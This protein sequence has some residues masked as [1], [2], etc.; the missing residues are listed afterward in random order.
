MKGIEYQIGL[1]YTRGP[2]RNR[3][4]SFVSLFSILGI[5]IGIATILTVLSVM[6]GFREEIREKVLNFTAHGLVSQF[7]GNIQDWRSIEEKLKQ[8]KQ[9][10]AY[11]PYLEFQ[12]ILKT[13]SNVRGT[14][15]RG[16]DP[17]TEQNVSDLEASLSEGAISDLTPK[18]WNVLLGQSLARN[19]G[20]KQGDRLVL[21]SSNVSHTPVGT[22]P[23]LRRLTVSGIFNTGMS[24][25]DNH[26]ALMNIKDAQLIMQAGKEVTGVQL[27]YDDLFQAPAISKKLRADLGLDYWV[28]SW[29]DRNRNFFKALEMEK[30]LLM[31]IMTLIIAVATFNI[32]SSLIMLVIEKKGDIAILKTMGMQTSSI[33]K[34]F[35]TQ[36]C[37]IGLSG[38]VLGTASGI[39]LAL[40]VER[41]VAGIENLT[42]SKFLS[43]DVYP[44]TEVPSQL[45]MADIIITALV[46][47]VLTVCA[48]LYPS[49][50]A[51]KIKPS[52]ALR[53]E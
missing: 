33:V 30:L 50:Y 31:I 15:F 29:T 49:F 48:T 2:K 32:V 11:S 34:I 16:I 22:I 13:P 4:I 36:G 43:P 17:E 44:I 14:L 1:R 21:L 10:V 51:A 35:I 5:T 26:I 37:L 52:E 46:A 53:Y 7:D 39:A 40:N 23:R 8:S 19:L 25:Y 41:I 3:F 24:Q 38:V 28:Y 47:F 9:V 27:R 42:G 6:N 12:G 45:M 20:V 18:S